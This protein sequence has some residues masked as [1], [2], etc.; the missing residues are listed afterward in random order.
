MKLEE[1][2]VWIRK[3]PFLKE[4]RNGPIAR[5]EKVTE[6]VIDQ[7]ILERKT[8]SKTSYDGQVVRYEEELLLDEPREDSL[9]YITIPKI[10]YNYDRSLLS[11][12]VKKIGIWG[13]LNIR[14]LGLEC[15]K[16]SELY[17]YHDGPFDPFYKC[18]RQEPR[19]IKE[20]VCDPDFIVIREQQFDVRSFIIARRT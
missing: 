3:Y 19:Y 13:S 8:H 9:R 15:F 12:G 4:M 1:I 11:W 16:K 5:T 17:D 20:E 7:E 18:L 10:S 2:S 14:M 6:T